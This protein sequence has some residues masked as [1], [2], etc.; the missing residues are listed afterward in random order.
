MSFT[1]YIIR[2]LS[3]KVKAF[4]KILCPMS[5]KRKSAHAALCRVGAFL[6]CPSFDL[7]LTFV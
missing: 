7:R 1:V 4:C 5:V 2:S 3:I 6:F